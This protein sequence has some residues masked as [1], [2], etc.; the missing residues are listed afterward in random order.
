MAGF[1]IAAAAARSARPFSGDEPPGEGIRPRFGAIGE[2]GS[3]AVVERFILTLKTE[4]TYRVLVPYR[5]GQFLRELHLFADW[6]N[7]HRPHMTLGGRTPHEVYEGLPPTNRA[8]RFE[9]RPRWP[10]GSP[11]AKPQTLV[12]GQPGVRLELQVTYH[13][14]RKHLP[15][16][17][18]LRAA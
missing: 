2:H 17:M 18:L 1:E 10:R 8:P 14:G 12:K 15:L 4:L 13:K 5:R 16:V 11:C 7:R 3:I 6:F 9:P